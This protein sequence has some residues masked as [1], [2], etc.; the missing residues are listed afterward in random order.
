MAEQMNREIDQQELQPKETL[1]R[2]VRRTEKDTLPPEVER[3]MNQRMRKEELQPQQ[4][5]KP[6]MSQPVLAPVAPT[7]PK[8]VLPVTR[9]TFRLGFKRAIGDAGRWLSVFLFRM[10]KM[11]KG[12]VTFK[13]DHD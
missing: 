11:K 1:L 10:I 9:S 5:V 12:E 13:D 2:D 6:G 3:W 8:V 4:T 7:N